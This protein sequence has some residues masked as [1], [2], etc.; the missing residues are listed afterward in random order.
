MTRPGRFPRALVLAL[1]LAAAAAAVASPPHARSKLARFTVAAT[2]DVLTHDAVLDAARVR[3]GPG[4]YEFRPL[5]RGVR[6]R[7]QHADLALCHQELVLGRGEPQPFPRFLAPLSLARA[8]ASLGWDACSVAS[9]HS[10]DHGSAGIESTIAALRRAGLRH[11]GTYLSP[12]SS[13]RTLML[14]VQGVRL[15]FLSYTDT[16]NGL[17]VPRPFQVNLT[18]RRAI[19]RDARRARRRGAAGVIVNLH[20]TGNFDPVSHQQRALIRELT[21]SPAVT[22]VIGQGAHAV[23]PLR[24]ANGKPV[25][26]GEGDLLHGFDHQ[27]YPQPASGL[28]AELHFAGSAKRVRVE[29]VRYLPLYVRERD[30]AVMAVGRAYRFGRANRDSLRTT[31][32]NV[33]RL[34]GRSRRI[35]P[36]PRR[37][38]GR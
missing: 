33:V 4:R 11:T 5:L 17:P 10:V 19:L 20:T 13:R 22:A 31:Y 36:I 1:I 29:S 27:P 32:R 28:L 15:A 9:N 6:S 26:F 2:G 23:R 14:R 8:T 7:I 24:F 3:A 38:P 35:Q 21:A 34:A 12:A 37:L 16:T 25:V 30:P 18:D